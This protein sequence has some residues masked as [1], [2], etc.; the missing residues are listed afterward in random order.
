MRERK[1]GNEHQSEGGREW[2]TGAVMLMTSLVTLPLLLLS[3]R[4]R[5]ARSRFPL[6]EKSERKSEI[7]RTIE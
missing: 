3:T 1:E 7:E 6:I 2:S 4:E 5:D